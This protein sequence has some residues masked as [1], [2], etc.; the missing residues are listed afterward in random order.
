M[1]FNLPGK[2]DILV[3]GYGFFQLKQIK[4]KVKLFQ[5]EKHLGCN[6]LP[7]I[8]VLKF[9][10]FAIVKNCEIKDLRM[11]ILVKFKH[12]K[13]NTCRIFCS[14]NS[15]LKIHSKICNDQMMFRNVATNNLFACSSLPRNFKSSD[16]L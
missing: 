10:S 8:L 3:S 5:T 13:V 9:A 1:L 4:T 15:H 2:F 7:L 16:F 14:N 6:G 12:S 11:K